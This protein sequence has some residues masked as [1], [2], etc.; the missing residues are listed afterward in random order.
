MEEERRSC[1]SQDERDANPAPPCAY[2]SLGQAVAGSPTQSG[3]RK[4]WPVATLITFVLSLVGAFF[5]F[6]SRPVSLHTDDVYDAATSPTGQYIATARYYDTIT[7]GYYH[8]ELRDVW[9]RQSAEVIELAAEGFNKL[10]WKDANTLRVYYDAAKN[11]DP[12]QDTMFVT[13][14]NAWRGVKIEYVPESESK[15]PVVSSSRSSEPH[16]VQ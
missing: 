13:K 3:T 5:W 10:D 12:E 2:A 1:P 14:P 16:H 4:R 15:P 7:Y 6:V 8:I 11:A 9:A